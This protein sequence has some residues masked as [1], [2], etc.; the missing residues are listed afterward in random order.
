MA[1]RDSKICLMR[2]ELNDFTTSRTRLVK[3][4]E[5]QNNSVNKNCFQNVHRLVECY[6]ERVRVMYPVEK[7]NEPVCVHVFALSASVPPQ[8]ALLSA[9]RLCSETGQSGSNL[10]PHTVSRTPPL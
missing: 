9:V 8:F 10:R 2:M 7:W 4:L 1:H 6:F 3:K 5:K